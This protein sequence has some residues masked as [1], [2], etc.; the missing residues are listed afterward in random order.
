MFL[1]V[2]LMREVEFCACVTFREVPAMMA[3]LTQVII[4][5]CV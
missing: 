2:V 3:C 1:C 5:A 4:D